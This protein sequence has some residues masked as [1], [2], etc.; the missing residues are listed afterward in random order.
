MTAQQVE[1]HYDAGCP[2]CSG[3]VEF[4]RKRDAQGKLKLVPL[5]AS[6]DMRGSCAETMAVVTPDGKRYE[7]SD[8]V[9][10]TMRRMGA[11][12]R[13]VA[14]AGRVVPRFARDGAYR[15]VAKNRHRWFGRT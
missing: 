3:V 4:A 14:A 8:A 6:C 15:F 13:V 1:V 9:L 7:R 11:G 10:E 5:Q 12:W 2:L